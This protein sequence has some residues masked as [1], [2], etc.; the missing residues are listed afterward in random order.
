MFKLFTSV[1]AVDAPVLCAEIAV[2]LAKDTIE[3]VPPA[4]MRSGFLQP[5]LHC[6]QEK[7]LVM[8][9]LGSASFEPCA[10]QA[11]VQDVDTEMHFRLHPS[12]RLV[13]SDRPE[14]HV[15]SCL[16]SPATQA[17]SAICIRGS[18]ISVQVPALRAVPVASCLHQSSRGS[19]CSLERMGGA[20]PQLSRRLAHT[21]TVSR[22]AV[23]T[24][25]PGAQTPQP[26]GS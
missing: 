21:R 16:D 23:C 2:L 3:P 14:G 26:V 19:P 25:G 17:I 7:W 5:L 4:E 24:Q 9:D 1:K 22:S 18:G 12:P 11:A 6:A 13:C 8:T 10:S 20:H 15:L